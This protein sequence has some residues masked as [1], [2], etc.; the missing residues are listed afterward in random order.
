MFGLVQWATSCTSRAGL[1]G[2]TAGTIR[3]IPGRVHRLRAG[4]SRVRSTQ[5]ITEP[6][7][8]KGPESPTP[9]WMAKLW[10]LWE[11]WPMWGRRL[12]AFLDRK[13]TRLNSSHLGI[14]Y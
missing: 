3:Y 4:G 5:L 8:P 2:G 9:G 14:S 13:S 10:A 7:I 1:V 6:G 12:A 11:Q